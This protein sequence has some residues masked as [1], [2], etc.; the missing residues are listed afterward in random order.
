MIVPRIRLSENEY[1][2]TQNKRITDTK[3]Y[4]LLL[5]SDPHGWLV[6][7]RAIRCINKVLQ[8]NRFDEVNING[9]LTD[10]PY[11]SNHNKR[12]FSEGILKGYTEVKEIEYTR[13]Q[14]LKPLRASTK[15]LIRARLGNHDERITKPFLLGKHQLNSLAI[16]YKHFNTTEYSEMLDLKANGVLYDPAPVHNYFGVFDTVHGL[17]IAKNASERNLITYMSSGSTGHTHRLTPQYSTNNK[18]TFVWFQSGCTRLIEQVEYIPTG[19]VADWQQG[20][21]EVTFYE[22]APGKYI[23]FGQPVPIVNG[24]CQ[25]N[26][27]IYNGNIN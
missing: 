7:L 2:Y 9:D 16:M 6:D 13:D 12:L 22:K 3:T 14:I 18:G 15:A 26:G 17:S 4:K 19:V 11:L 10:M 27:V 1:N 23:L 25:Y 5:F 24:I 8:G 21:V 20:F